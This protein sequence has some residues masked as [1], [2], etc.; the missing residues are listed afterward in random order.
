MQGNFSLSAVVTRPDAGRCR[1]LRMIAEVKFHNVNYLPL[2]HPGFSTAQTKVVSVKRVYH[3]NNKASA[4]SARVSIRR[5]PIDLAAPVFAVLA[6]FVSFALPGL[7]LSSAQR[8]YLHS[9][10]HTRD[11]RVGGQG[12]G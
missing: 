1:L 5:V 6:S 2:R 8:M 3:P 7:R 4:I 11:S 9:I 12:R 10:S